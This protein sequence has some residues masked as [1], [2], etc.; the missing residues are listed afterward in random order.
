MNRA[1]LKETLLLDGPVG[2]L[3]AILERPA[4]GEPVAVA[5]VCHPH[6]LHEGTMHNKVAHTLARAFVELGAEAL[7]FNF[8]GVGRSAGRHD[9]G[10]GETDDALAAL[11]WLQAR[12]PGAPLWLAGFSFGAQVALR[13]ALA[14]PVTRLVTVAPPVGRIDRAAFRVP[15]A[16]WLLIQGEADE[17]VN[18]HDVIEW[19]MALEPRPTIVRVPGTGHYFHGRLNEL[20]RI[21]EA[22]IRGHQNER[23]R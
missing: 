9:N 8:R 7:R 15:A 23:G 19:A 10:V 18:A 5:V 13:A 12:R 21:I 6:P 17:V 3:E 1:P 2:P 14:R 20:K 4:E 11:D 16:D 22:H